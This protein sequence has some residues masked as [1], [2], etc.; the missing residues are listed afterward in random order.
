MHFG[1]SVFLDVHEKSFIAF[2]V[3]ALIHMLL[4]CILWSWHTVVQIQTDT[5]KVCIF[6]D[7][8]DLVINNINYAFVLMVIV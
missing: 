6:V 2:V 5:L 4:T 8:C 1:F 3:F 7:L